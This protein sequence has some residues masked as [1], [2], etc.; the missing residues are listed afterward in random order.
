[1]RKLNPSALIIIL[2]KILDKLLYNDNYEDIDKN[3]SDSNVGTRKKRNIKDHLLLVHG[4]INSV[5]RGNEDCV[6]IQ[7]Y[8]IEKAFDALWLEDCLNDIFDNLSEK[9]RNDKFSRLY[10]SSKTNMVAVKTAVGLTERINVQT[11]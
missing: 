8:D 6:D 5:I 1:M 10:E 7:I 4:V 3:M 9:N 2:K 11:L